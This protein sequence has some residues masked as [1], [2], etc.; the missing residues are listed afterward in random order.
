MGEFLK[1]GVSY[2]YKSVSNIGSWDLFGG[3]RGLV[4][5]NRNYTWGFTRSDSS[6]HRKGISVKVGDIIKS[7]PESTFV[8]LSEHIGDAYDSGA[9]LLL[10]YD[11]V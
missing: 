2:K 1:G 7:P 11:P 8:N 6:V 4:T 5:H 10:K 3:W 9:K